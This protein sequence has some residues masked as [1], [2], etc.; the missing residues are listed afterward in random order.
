[1]PTSSS[2][3]KKVRVMAA[4]TIVFA[5]LHHDFWFWNDQTLVM[6]FMPI[7]LLYHMLFSIGSAVLWATTMKIAW[8]THIEEWADEFDGPA[9]SASAGSQGDRK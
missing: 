1:M 4:V 3:K 5:L 8:P 2:Y 7:G 6:G 9:G